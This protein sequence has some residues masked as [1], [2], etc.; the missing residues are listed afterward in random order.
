MHHNV[1]VHHFDQ[2]LLLDVTYTLVDG[3]VT[4]V[5]EVTFFLVFR[6]RTSVEV[7]AISQLAHTQ[8]LHT[9]TSTTSVSRLPTI[10]NLAVSYHR[11][12]IDVTK[13]LQSIIRRHEER[14]ATLHSLQI[15]REVLLQRCF[16]I[17]ATLYEGVI[18]TYHSAHHL[19]VTA[20]ESRCE[21]R[22]IVS[23]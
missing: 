1:M 13:V 5:V 9:I 23:R 14:E 22:S 16:S 20:I 6:L 2:E 21:H 15:S 4:F 8:S 3:Y 11:S 18:G 17:I 7:K 10:I 12:G 19:C